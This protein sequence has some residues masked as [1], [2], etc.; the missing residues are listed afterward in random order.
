MRVVLFFGSVLLL[1]CAGATGHKLP[2]ATPVLV[3]SH[4]E[5]AVDV[6]LLC[7]DHDATRL[8]L[9]TGKGTGEYQISPRRRRCAVGLN[10]FLVPAK[11]SRGYWVGPFLP[12]EDEQ[13]ILIIERYAGLSVANVT[14]Q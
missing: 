10:F 7:G 6:Y 9:V 8:G 4:N 5:S 1:A 11:R 14:S 13:V 2:K 12:R 3:R